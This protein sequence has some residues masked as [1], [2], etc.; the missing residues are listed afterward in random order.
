[1]VTAA[2][3][4]TTWKAAAAARRLARP[5]PSARPLRARRLPRPRR[6]RG[7]TTWMTIFRS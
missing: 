3:A 1:V 6:R 5:Q 4:A 2:V 7:L